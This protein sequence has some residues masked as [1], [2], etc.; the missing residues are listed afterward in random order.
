MVIGL[1]FGRR[2]AGDSNDFT[3]YY[4]A[5]FIDRFRALKGTIKC[6]DLTGADFNTPEGQQ[7]WQTNLQDE[8]CSPLLV[9][10]VEIINDLLAE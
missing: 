6:R 4:G 3:Y 5:E 10:A 1:Q 9:Q 7:L 2:Q 8:I